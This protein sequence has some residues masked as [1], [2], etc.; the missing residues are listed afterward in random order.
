MARR[1]WTVLVGAATVMALGA[2][3]C[4]SPEC[5]HPPC[6]L[7]TAIIIGVTSAAG[8][9]ITGASAEVSG[10]VTITPALKCNTGSLQ[11]TCMVLGGAGNYDVRVSAPGFQAVEQSI[12]V[13][14]SQPLCGCGSVDTRM[15]TIA[16]APQR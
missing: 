6:A 2:S 1:R 5:V 16:L 8:A 7:P 15:V 12:V 11:N 14:G 3:R 9:P 13:T 10:A 4:S